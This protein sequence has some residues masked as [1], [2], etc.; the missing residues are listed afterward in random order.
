[1]RVGVGD[2]HISFEALSG[3][4]SAIL[5]RLFRNSRLVVKRI[6]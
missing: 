2:E 3:G 1:M 4:W 6:C 5:S